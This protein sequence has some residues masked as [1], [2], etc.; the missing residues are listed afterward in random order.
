MRFAY[1]LNPIVIVLN[2]GGYGIERQ[3][4]DRPSPQP[5]HY[6]NIPEIVGGRIGFVI[7]TQDKFDNCFKSVYQ[8]LEGFSILERT[9][10]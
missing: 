4:L 8:Y 3:F 6:K 2:N 9:Y 5:R 7:D 1:K 10:D